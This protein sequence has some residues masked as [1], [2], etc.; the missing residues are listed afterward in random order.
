MI[1]SGKN[2]SRINV[3]EDALINLTD[4]KATIA[5]IA[6]VEVSKINDSYNFKSLFTN[7][8]ESLRDYTYSEM[9][10][11]ITTSDVT[12]RNYTHK[13]LLFDDGSEGLYNLSID[14]LETK[15]LL[16]TRNL[17]LTTSDSEMYTALIE[18]LESL[19]K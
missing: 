7:S 10:E 2:V 13:Y 14:P 17:P 3:T 1:I 16:N 5:S 6:G 15:N 18:K 11:N 19:K 4:L 8:E 12:I 9:G